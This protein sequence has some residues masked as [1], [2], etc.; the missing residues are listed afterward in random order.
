MDIRSSPWISHQCLRKAALTPSTTKPI[1]SRIPIS[2]APGASSGQKQIQT[3]LPIGIR[4]TL[5]N[6]GAAT[7]V[8]K[9]AWPGRSAKNVGKLM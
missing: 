6:A 4:L 2:A 8:E 1:I 5:K 7:D 3:Q 9:F